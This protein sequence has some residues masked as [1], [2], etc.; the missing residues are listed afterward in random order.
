MLHINLTKKIVN[1]RFLEMNGVHDLFAVVNLFVTYQH[2]F[3]FEQ[4]TINN[5]RTD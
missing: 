2:F 5:I 3:G 1:G 4:E